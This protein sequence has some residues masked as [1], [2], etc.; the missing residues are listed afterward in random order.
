M[1]E[2]EKIKMDY[3]GEKKAR[4]GRQEQGD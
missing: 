2:G 1:E 4:K 3:D